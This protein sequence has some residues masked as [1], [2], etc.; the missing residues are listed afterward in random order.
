[1]AQGAEVPA[2]AQVAE[3]DVGAQQAAAAVQRDGGVLHVDVVHAI[4]EVLQ[5]EVR[6][7][8]L[9]DQ[10]AGVEVQAELRAIRKLGQQLLGGIVVK[11][12]LTGVHL[13]GEHHAVLLELVQDGAPQAHD[14]VEAVLD[15]LLG[16]LREGVEIAPD[17]GAGEAGDDLH[18]ELLRHGGGLLHGLDAPV[19][20]GLRLIRQG[21]GREVVQA[22]IG[23][24]AHAL[25]DDVAGQRLHDQAVLLQIFFDPGDVGIVGQGAVNIDAVAPAGN[26]QTVI[27]HL[28]GEYAQFIKG[29]IRP[30][31]G[32]ERYRSSHFL[33]PPLS[34]FRVILKIQHFARLWYDFPRAVL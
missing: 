8:A 32:A 7:D 31:A 27:A 22:R 24:I 13:K 20:D 29:H 19:A 28:L 33:L 26:L 2:A 9:P 16:G 21:R 14:L 5:E 1:M 30:L 34:I 6:L 10:M 18:A 4:D 17:R 12:D 23:R 25:A 11:G 3:V 15:H